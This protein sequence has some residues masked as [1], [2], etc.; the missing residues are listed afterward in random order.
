MTQKGDAM[1]VLTRKKG[2]RIMIDGTIEVV[3]LSIHRSNIKLGISAPPE[4]S[5]ERVEA[6][7]PKEEPVEQFSA[8]RRALRG[9]SPLAAHRPSSAMPEDAPAQPVST[10]Y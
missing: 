1:L 6:P 8:A 10:A 2:E 9:D 3:V 5:I 4:V 7:R